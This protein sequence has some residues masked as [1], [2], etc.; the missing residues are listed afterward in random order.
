[1]TKGR[2]STRGKTPDALR[3]AETS[4]PILQTK[5]L[6]LT[7]EK[8]EEESR[9]RTDRDTRQRRERRG[10]GLILEEG[11]FVVVDL[12]SLRECLRLEEPGR[13]IVQVETDHRNKFLFFLLSDGCTMMFDFFESLRIA[14]RQKQARSLRGGCLSLLYP[15]LPSC[16]A[17][18]TLPA[19]LQALVGADA[20]R[21]KSMRLKPRLCTPKDV[22]ALLTHSHMASACPRGGVPASF[23][24]PYPSPEAGV[25]R[26]CVRTGR[27]SRTAALVD[28]TNSHSKLAKTHDAGPSC[29]CRA[30]CPDWESPRSSV[31][32]WQLRTGGAYADSRNRDEKGEPAH[33]TPGAASRDT[34]LTESE[35]LSDL[36][37]LTWVHGNMRFAALPSKQ[38]HRNFRRIVPSPSYPVHSLSGNDHTSRNDA[39]RCCSGETHSVGCRALDECRSA[40]A[41]AKQGKCEMTSEK[42]RASVRSATSVRQGSERASEEFYHRAQGLAHGLPPPP[43]PPCVSCLL[44]PSGTLPGRTHDISF[45]FSSPSCSPVSSLASD[46]PSSEALSA[47]ELRNPVPPSAGTS[48]V[49]DSL[50]LFYEDEGVGRRDGSSPGEDADATTAVPMVFSSPGCSP[51]WSPA[52]GQAGNSAPIGT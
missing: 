10:L 51:P 26:T 30:C 35:E 12:A 18:L 39:G 43:P 29:V 16:P 23:V 40:T 38:P 20:P 45:G 41:L 11:A 3:V 21:A 1:M 32:R 52:V 33:D 27:E 31:K 2:L 48:S 17:S 14:E 4:S 50:S 22:A 36:D 9:G 34:P 8:E 46:F 44:F 6:V 28:G 7:D 47:R 5:S 49:A 15:V 13:A 24:S 37:D 19:C 42:R 25:R